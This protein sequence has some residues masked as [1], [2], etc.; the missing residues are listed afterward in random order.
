MSLNSTSAVLG[1]TRLAPS[2]TG[3]LHLGN[4]RTFLINWLIAKQRNWHIDLR[5][6]DL[7]G[8]RVKKG[9][10]RQAIEDLQW[11]GLT[12]DETPIVQSHRTERYAAAIQSLIHSGHAYPCVCSRRDIE[13]AAS[14]P[15]STDGAIQYPGTCKGR[16]AS[17][18]AARDACGQD[19]A[20]RFQ[21]PDRTIEFVDEFAGARSFNASNDLGDFI[22][23]KADGTPAYQLAVVV[24]DMEMKIDHVI[25]GDDLID[26]T[27]RQLLLMEAINPNHCPPRYLHL[28]LIL[29]SDGLRLAKRHGD[30][31]LSYYRNRGVPVERILRLLGRWCGVV[32]DGKAD[33]VHA[34]LEHFNLSNIDHR[35]IVFTAADEK[36]LLDSIH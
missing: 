20:I 30:S 23:E 9:A 28:P 24:D 5:I 18:Q 8:P 25:R 4:A 27:A 33:S 11:L 31:R 17:V 35:P 1:R 2:P 29:G 16:F 32:E 19:P 7:D 34:M 10:D 26:S 14:A 21:V 36:Q 3:S 22:I 13:I 6:E 12:W 15:H